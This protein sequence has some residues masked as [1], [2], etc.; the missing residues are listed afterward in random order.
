MARDEATRGE[1]VLTVGEVVGRNLRQLRQ[2]RSQ[3]Q[4]DA[5]RFLR[6]K[7]LEWTRDHVASLESGRR[8]NIEVSALLAL[9]LAY[10]VP[11]TRWFE[12]EGNVSIGADTWL[13][14]QE[15][16]QGLDGAAWTPIIV[17]E[18]LERFFASQGADADAT[19]A[20][21]LEVP[22]A[23]VLRLAAQLWNRTVTEEREARLGDASDLPMRSV[24][25]RRGHITR[26][27]TNEIRDAMQEDQS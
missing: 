21:R 13:Q 24:Q 17:G 14:L 1:E 5:G 12:G 26:Q 4:D 10:R 8:E 16:A 6:S 20:E 3:T 18:R 25:A 23:D 11:L 9:S 15:L 19:V 22:V 27:L 7:G 2:D